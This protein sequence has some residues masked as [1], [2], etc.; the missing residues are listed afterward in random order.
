MNE[1][2]KQLKY[3]HCWVTQIEE[4]LNKQIKKKILWNKFT[5]KI[6]KKIEEYF[7]MKVIKKLLLFQKLIYVSSATRKKMIE[8]HHDNALTEHFEI[9]KI[10]KLIFRNYYF[11][12][13][14]QKMKKHIWQ[15]KQCQKNKSKWY[16]SYEKLQSLKTVNESWQSITINFIVK[17]SKFRKSITKFKYDLIMIMMN[18]F[19][20]KAYFVSFHEE[21]KTEKMIYLFEW[22]IIAN[23]KV[24]TKMISDR[25]TQFKLKFW[26]TLTA[27]KKI[28]TKMSTIEHLQ[29]DDQ[30][31]QLNQILKQYL[32]CYVNYQQNNWIE[33]L[34][35]AQFAYNNNTQTFT[36]ISLFQAEYD[37]DMQINN[38]IIKS[39]DNNNMT[40]QQ[41]KK[42]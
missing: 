5:K 37:K 23:H 33:L 26:Q 10:I 11:L 3:T 27:L 38:K 20:K 19:I 34:F 4:F 16:K 8:Q 17:L 35:T 12:Q 9:N 25:D 2:K 36:E 7:K 28:K 30:I 13:M 18:K 42:M 39:T 14:K 40:I 41:D 15:C 29:T 6:I 21:M 24:S 31:E 22:H 32:K 1:Q